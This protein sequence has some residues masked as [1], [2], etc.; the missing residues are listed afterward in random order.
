MNKA[1]LGKK[2]GMTQIF[3]DDGTVIPVTVVEAGPC[4]VSQVKTDEK[5]GYNAVQ[6]A[7][8]DAKEKTV[9]KPLMGHLKKAGLGAKKYL[10]EFRLSDVSSYTSG[11]EVKCDIFKTGDIV[12]VSGVTRGRGFT[13]VIQRW[14]NHRLKMTH[15]TGPV[16]REVGSMGANSTPSRVMKNKKMPGHYGHEN[17]TIQNLEVVKVDAEKNI[18]LIRG[19]VPGPKGGLVAVRQAVKSAK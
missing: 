18:M 17:A 4:Y 16:H 11:K 14:N 19:S 8:Y 7:F 6:F 12:D 3:S 2:L 15:G 13:G 10:K 1:I 5:D 9:T